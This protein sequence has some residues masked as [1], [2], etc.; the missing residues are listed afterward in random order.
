V[1]RRESREVSLDHI[2]RDWMIR[3]GFSVGGETARGLHDQAH[4]ITASSIKFVWETE[5]AAATGMARGTL[6]EQGLF[7]GARRGQGRP[8]SSRTGW[9]SARCSTGVIRRK[10]TAYLALNAQSLPRL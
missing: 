7:V 3:L 1:V 8:R 4:R 10:D 6:V 9:C 5:A 2:M